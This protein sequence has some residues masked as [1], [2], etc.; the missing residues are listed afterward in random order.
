MLSDL[1]EAWPALDN[2]AWLM[3]RMLRNIRFELW[4]T[5]GI[6][7]ATRFH[8]N[9]IR[10]SILALEYNVHSPF[11]FRQINLVQ[12]QCIYL[13]ARNTFYPDRL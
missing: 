12:S 5:L 11:P 7:R 4:L 1:G 8:Q 2:S 6:Y 3:M 10:Q 9:V 13:S